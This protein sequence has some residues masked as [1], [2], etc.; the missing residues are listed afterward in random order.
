M[1]AK[2]YTDNYNLCQWD[3]EDLVNREEFNQDNSRIDQGLSSIS[4]KII[5]LRAEYDQSNEE[6]LTKL[7]TLESEFETLSGVTS[8]VSTL[9]T[10]VN[11]LNTSMDTCYKTVSPNVYCRCYTGTGATKT[12]TI[13]FPYA[14]K[15]AIVWQILV[16][17]TGHFDGAG[18]CAS[19]AM[20]YG[21]TSTSVISFSNDQV[22][23]SSDMMSIVI[24][25]SANTAYTDYFVFA[26]N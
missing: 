1:M 5:Q 12:Q 18:Y 16:G 14:M 7:A 9:Q 13:K 11:S 8:T 20:D 2:N 10:Q 15:S 21:A 19:L 26:Y 17:T 22:Q 4:E 23:F 3:E 24:K 25:N 6:F